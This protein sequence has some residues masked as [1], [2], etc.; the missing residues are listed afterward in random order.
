ML[1]M[2]LHRVGRR[3]DPSYRIV[4]TDKRTGPKS[5]K[6][7]A[8]LGSYNPKLKRT[9]LDNQAASDWINKGVQPSDT[10]HNILVT[11]GVLKA[12]K[13]NVLP[14]KSAPE[15]KEEEGVKEQPEEKVE[16]NETTEEKE[17]TKTAEKTETT[18][19]K[20]ETKKD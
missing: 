14:R 13:R 5:N 3:N 7:V 4:V 15:V 2:R 10:M 16:T 18:E 19:D 17:E 11:Q 1:M 8:I 12:K 20:E 6:Y 9:I